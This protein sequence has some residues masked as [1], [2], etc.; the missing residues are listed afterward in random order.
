MTTIAIV[1]ESTGVDSLT[2][3]AF[4]GEKESSGRTAGQALDALTSQ[5]DESELSTLVIVQRLLPDR[6]FTAEQR[7]RLQEL[8]SRWRAARDKNEEFNPSEQAELEALVEAEM[9]GA[10]QRAEAIIDELGT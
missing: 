8:M 2:W 5:L 3:R 10:T 1:P 6:F 7:Q 9:E 4:A